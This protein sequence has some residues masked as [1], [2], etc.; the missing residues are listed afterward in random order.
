MI[1]FL[2][3]ATHI[4]TRFVFIQV[5]KFDFRGRHLLDNVSL[6]GKSRMTSEQVETEVPAIP[7]LEESF[8]IHLGSQMKQMH[9][10]RIMSADV[11]HLCR[12]HLHAKG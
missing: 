6:K 3:V 8:T 7:G 11:L 5:L 1:L 12:T 9:N 2:A 4:R 10:I